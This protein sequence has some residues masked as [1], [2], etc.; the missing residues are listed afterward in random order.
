MDGNFR[1]DGRVIYRLRKRATRA[2]QVAVGFMA[3][4]IVTV[5][6]GL[7]FFLGLSLWQTWADGRERTLQETIDGI[8]DQKGL[9]CTNLEGFLV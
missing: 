2:R 6:L 8:V 1:A 9:C 3:L 5:A 7:L 4:M